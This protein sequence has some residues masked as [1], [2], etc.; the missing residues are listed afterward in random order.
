MIKKNGEMSR[1]EN[2]IESGLGTKNGVFKV[3][4]DSM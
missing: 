4:L 3:Y 1:Y 2:H